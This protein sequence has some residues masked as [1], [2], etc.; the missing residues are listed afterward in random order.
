MNPLR[1]GH[2]L[3]NHSTIE[4]DEN[5][6]KRIPG[7]YYSYWK[8]QLTF[9]LI[10]DWNRYPS[11]FLK[12]PQM[13]DFIILSDD[14]NYYYP[15]VYF[16][17]FSLLKDYYIP[18]NDTINEVPIQFYYNGMGYQRFQMQ[19]QMEW[20]WKMQENWGLA[21]E[22]EF[23]EIKRIFLETNP[24]FLGVTM[25]V[26]ILHSVFD[27]LAFKNDIS[28]WNNAKSYEG[29]STKTLFLNAFFQ[30]VIL[31]YLLDNE[32]SWMIIG[33]SAVGVV[34]E[35]WKI[36]KVLRVKLFWWKN[37]IPLL[38]FRDRM[39]YGGNKTRKY[40]NMAMKYLMYI[41]FPLVIGSSIYSLY[42]N[43]YKSWYSWVLS[44]LTSF[45]YTF[46]FI[47]M[48]PQLFINY[49]M[50]SVAHLPWK[51][52]IYK[53]L[54]TFIDDLFAFIVKMPTLHRLAC[55]RDDIVFFI[56][57]YQRYIYPVDKK[58]R[59][60]FG[61]TGEEE[62]RLAALRKAGRSHIT[63]EDLQN[64]NVLNEI[65]KKDDKKEESNKKEEEKEEEIK[66][67][68]VKDNKHEG[69]RRRGAASEKKEDDNRFEELPD[70]YEEQEEEKDNS[71]EKKEN[72]KDKDNT[73]SQVQEFH[74]RSKYDIIPMN[75]W[76]MTDDDD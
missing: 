18:L 35:L 5:I 69:L 44:S 12:M 24:W 76:I 28:F 15:I 53:S 23:D 59:N 16:N 58:R 46:G 47:T 75:E 33:S 1:E 36:R 9:H 19:S 57:L 68:T 20:M 55:F 63:F 38:K 64:P 32:T 41:L 49:K 42:Y 71:D 37:A 60:E 66:E 29:L 67:P 8:P 3:V 40:D 43:K 56:Y 54:N 51:A 11:S 62:E 4:L 13:K 74:H 6:T 2:N 21:V 26:S 14:G 31:L 10:C 39:S 22:D 73:T 17:E 52:M 30:F 48:T 61:L 70:D 7:E 50:K 34:I 45:V 27:F 65:N 72:E 25:F